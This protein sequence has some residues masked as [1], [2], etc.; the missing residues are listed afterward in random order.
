MYH[1]TTATIQLERAEDVASVVAVVAAAARRLRR[2]VLM[3]FRQ[4]AQ[5]SPAS[6]GRGTGCSDIC[7]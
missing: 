6:G 4:L 1:W 5:S 3:R 7:N 2:C